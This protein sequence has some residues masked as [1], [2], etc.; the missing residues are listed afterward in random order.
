MKRLLLF[1]GL[2]VGC[3][4]QD[5]NYTKGELNGLFWG[6]LASDN[7]VVFLQGVQVGNRL[8]PAWLLSDLQP[9]CSAPSQKYPRVSNG[10]LVK[11][12]DMFYSNPANVPLPIGVAVTYTF[13]RLM[14][15]SKESLEEF[16]TN[17][18][19]VYSK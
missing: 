1:L 12:V 13:L 17:A 2:V 6:K 8:V 7:K 19:Q 3:F 10:V 14:G 15:S 11:E 9:T 4:G 18:I 5:L 16:R